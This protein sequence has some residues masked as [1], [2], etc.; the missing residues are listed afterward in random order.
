MDN[1]SC[2]AVLTPRGIN[3][4]PA[5]LLHPPGAQGNQPSTYHCFPSHPAVP[6]VSWEI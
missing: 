2:M 3:H 5:P 1:L 4:I 6:V